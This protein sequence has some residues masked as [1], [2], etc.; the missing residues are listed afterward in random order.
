M[1]NVRKSP[2]EDLLTGMDHW[3]YGAPIPNLLTL[4][5]F[6]KRSFLTSEQLTAAIQ[7][8]C[9]TPQVEL[10]EPLWLR[11]I[12]SNLSTL[13]Y[14]GQ[15]AFCDG[16]PSIYGDHPLDVDSYA[17]MI[18][19]GWSKRRLQQGRWQRLD[20]ADVWYNDFCYV[21]FQSRACF[22]EPQHILDVIRH[23]YSLVR[24]LQIPELARHHDMHFY[25]L[26]ERFLTSHQAQAPN[27][28][29]DPLIWSP[30]DSLSAE[31]PLLYT[32]WQASLR[33][34]GHIRSATIISV[35]KMAAIHESIYPNDTINL[36]SLVGTVNGFVVH[37]LERLQHRSAEGMR[38]DAVTSAFSRLV[39]LA[40]HLDKWIPAFSDQMDIRIAINNIFITEDQLN[41]VHFHDLSGT[42]NKKASSK[43]QNNLRAIARAKYHNDI[44]IFL[45]A[46]AYAKLTEKSINK[47]SEK[48]GSL[49]AWAGLAADYALKNERLITTRR[50][51]GAS[52]N[53]SDKE[54][55]IRFAKSVVYDSDRYV[56]ELSKKSTHEPIENT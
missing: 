38:T 53:A 5:E 26:M 47:P 10:S 28:Q 52:D 29:S 46:A 49:D 3:I 39:D 33:L 7:S 31:R 50:A 12:P 13:L 25:S 24:V 36:A 6:Q 22:V 15:K 9:I 45:V 11:R 41:N 19:L 18:N 35:E 17:A 30:Y 2:F 14:R 20:I 54:S 51:L 27:E 40:S 34:S 23:G 44:A 37:E 55:V 16:V 48:G 4:S 32:D 8:G 1:G 42:Q 21:A 56:T 43:R